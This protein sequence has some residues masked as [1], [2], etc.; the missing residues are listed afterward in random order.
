MVNLP[1]LW[2]RSIGISSAIPRF[3]RMKFLMTVVTFSYLDSGRPLNRRL[4]RLCRASW[5]IDLYSSNVILSLCDWT[6]FSI[7]LV[8]LHLNKAVSSFFSRLTILDWFIDIVL[9]I[10]DSFWS[11]VILS[12]FSNSCAKQFDPKSLLFPPVL[13]L[14][15]FCLPLTRI[16][17]SV[18]ALKSTFLALLSVSDNCT[19]KTD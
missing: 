2:A 9:R 11:T 17:S 8:C 14:C 19:E 4:L 1:S 5:S 18:S 7:S 15:L 3:S 12:M 6:D 16:H 13:I 10:S